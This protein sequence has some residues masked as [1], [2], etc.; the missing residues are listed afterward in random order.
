MPSF[1]AI[2]RGGRASARNA[3]KGNRTSSN[4][5][6]SPTYLS[7]LAEYM[8]TYSD[9]DGVDD[10]TR[11]AALA[12]PSSSSR[13]AKFERTNR[14]HFDDELLQSEMKEKLEKQKK[15]ERGREGERDCERRERDR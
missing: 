5:L 13:A 2:G 4:A 9:F 7:D 11:E 8:R 1:L 15:G 14:F 10:E 3:P 12:F 6:V